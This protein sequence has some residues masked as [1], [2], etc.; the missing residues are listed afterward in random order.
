MATV[1]ELARTWKV[2]EETGGG[3]K[4]DEKTEVDG[5]IGNVIREGERLG[6]P[7]PLARA[8]LNVYMEVE[9][10]QRALGVQNYRELDKVIG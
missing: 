9:N 5:I 7:T 6:G 10:R 1:E 4:R 2:E 3:L 8:T